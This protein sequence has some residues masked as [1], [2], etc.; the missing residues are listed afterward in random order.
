MIHLIHL[1]HEVLPWFLSLITLVGVWQIGK[2]PRLGWKVGLVA[3][4]SWVIFDVWWKAWGLI[5][6]SVAL[7]VMYSWQL[8][9]AYPKRLWRNRRSLKVPCDLPYDAW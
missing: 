6:L 3:N 2:H 7:L 9:G 8:W 1:I 5:P 4:A